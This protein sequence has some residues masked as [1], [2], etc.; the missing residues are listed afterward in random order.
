MFGEVIRLSEEG[1]L[2]ALRVRFNLFRPRT[3]EKY[4]TMQEL[5]ELTT[6]ATHE[7]ELYAPEDW[8]FMGWL[9]E[10]YREGDRELSELRLEGMELLQWL[11]R[12]GH[13]A[14]VELADQTVGSRAVTD[15]AGSPGNS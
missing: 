4:R 8:E 7:Q 11:V 2:H 1:P 12:W 5:V 6:R 13:T 14:R 9:G 3:G 10:M 15:A